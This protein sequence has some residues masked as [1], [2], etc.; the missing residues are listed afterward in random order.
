MHAPWIEIYLFESTKVIL[1]GDP[2]YTES[3]VEDSGNTPKQVRAWAH[4]TWLIITFNV[5]LF[6][7]SE[8]KVGVT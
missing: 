2:R 4:T 7:I 5:A 1:S 3:I 8:M 6:S